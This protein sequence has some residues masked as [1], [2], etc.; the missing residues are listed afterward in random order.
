MR[1]IA[2]GYSG[3]SLG[4]LLTPILITPV[5]AAWGWGAA[6]WFTGTVGA[7][8]LALWA[9]VSRR[10][11]LARPPAVVK[12]SAAPRWNEAWVWAF[13]GAYAL[14]AAPLAFVLYQSPLYLSAA[15]HKSQLEIGHVLWIPP[16]VWEAGLFFWG[17]VTD[18]LMRSGASQLALRRQLFLTMLLSLPLAALPRVGSY[19]LVL[20][21]LFFGMFVVSG[22]TIG[23]LAYAARQY[24]TGHSGLITGLGSGTWSIVVALEMPVAGRLFDLHRY[25]AAFAL[26]ALL[27]VAGYALWR[28]FDSIG[29]A[30]L[31]RTATQEAQIA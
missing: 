4:A 10:R 30:T 13:L 20:A 29:L 11:D 12:S 26:A 21:L 25:D 22:F 19:P 16:L 31:K 15:L 23:A 2:I 18:R 6:F 8:W 7:L 14:G 17:W 1:G 3:G 24:S 9:A 27:P 5:A 28:A